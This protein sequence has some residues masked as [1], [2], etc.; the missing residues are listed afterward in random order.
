MR[1][2]FALRAGLAASP[3]LLT[4]CFNPNELGDPEQALISVF[5][6]EGTTVEITEVRDAEGV[7]DQTEIIPAGGQARLTPLDSGEDDEACLAYP[8]VATNSDGHE[9]ERL[10]AGFCW[11]SR[12]YEWII[13]GEVD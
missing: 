7:E 13:D 2:T 1:R 4:A 11:T 3:L 8:L 6:Q 10:P 12:Y 5:N 9:V